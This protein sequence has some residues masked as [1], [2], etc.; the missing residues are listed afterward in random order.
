M[1]SAA[2][3]DERY[4]VETVP[5]LC[6]ANWIPPTATFVPGWFDGGMDKLE[7]TQLW[8]GPAQQGFEYYKLY[9]SGLQSAAK[10]VHPSSPEVTM[11]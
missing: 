3:H 9:W 1:T 4:D 10:V 2:H 8:P 7:I 5:Q 6:R 11:K